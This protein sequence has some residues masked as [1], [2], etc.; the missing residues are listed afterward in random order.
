MCGASFLPQ[1]PA[2]QKPVPW[3]PLYRRAMLDAAARR[4][5]QIA[6]TAGRG[7][8]R[9]PVQQIAGLDFS[10]LSALIERRYSAKK[11]VVAQTQ[12]PPLPPDVRCGRTAAPPGGRGCGGRPFRTNA[13]SIN[14]RSGLAVTSNFR[15]EGA[16]QHEMVR[17]AKPAQ[18]PCQAH[19]LGGVV[20]LAIRV[21]VRREIL[22]RSRLPNRTRPGSQEAAL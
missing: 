19:F 16:C 9:A 17:R 22:H 3:L 15:P 20:S 11:L 8:S 2:T 18:D 5:S 10:I 7:Y 1:E 4:R 13:R 14:K 12:K 6:G 21:D